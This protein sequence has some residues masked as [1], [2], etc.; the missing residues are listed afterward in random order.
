M[1]KRWSGE[2]DSGDGIAPL[3]AVRPLTAQAT[4]IRDLRR[5]AMGDQS[6]NDTREPRREPKTADK[7]GSYYYDDATGYQRYDPDDEGEEGQ[8]ENDGEEAG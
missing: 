1:A 8:P 4:L 6:E 7:A 5:F 3:R 2:T